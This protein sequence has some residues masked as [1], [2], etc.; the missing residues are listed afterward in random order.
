[1]IEGVRKKLVLADQA[2]RQK[3]GQDQPA[4]FQDG[5]NN[6]FENLNFKGLTLIKV[7]EKT[8]KLI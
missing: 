5:L 8:E 2:D 7:L 3:K 4:I 6:L 1:M